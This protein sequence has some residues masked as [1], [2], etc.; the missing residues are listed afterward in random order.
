[1]PFLE[2]GRAHRRGSLGDTLRHVVGALARAKLDDPEVGEAM[3]MERILAHDTL[4]LLAVLSNGENDAPLARDLAS[5]NEEASG[6]VVLVQEGDV[7][8]HRRIDFAEVDLVCELDEEHATSLLDGAR[9][10]SISGVGR[11]AL[12]AH[13]R[14]PQGMVIWKA[15]P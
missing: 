9:L 6:L 8:L 7:G 15:T 3:T 1:C 4:D 12:D 5:G 13:E 11:P 14:I 2:I 10:S